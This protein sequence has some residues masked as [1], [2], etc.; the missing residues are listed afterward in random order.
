MRA[1]NATHG[2]TNVKC[3]TLV[4]SQVKS[5]SI[6]SPPSS[7][8]PALKKCD[9][10]AHNLPAFRSSIDSNTFYA[11]NKPSQ[12]RK[13]PILQ[14]YNTLSPQKQVRTDQSRPPV[15]HFQFVLL[16]LTIHYRSSRLR[17]ISFPR[18]VSNIIVVCR[19]L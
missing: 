16:K 14:P 18:F 12:K 3:A 5:N 10:S 2:L 13:Q 1:Y 4:L 11:A 15:C 7:V 17:A 9:I 19:N 8:V 6:M